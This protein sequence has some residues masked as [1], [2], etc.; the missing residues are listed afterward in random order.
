MAFNPAAAH[1]DESQQL[2]AAFG[3]FM[4]VRADGNVRAAE[5]V[6]DRAGG[7][8]AVI[9]KPVSLMGVHGNPRS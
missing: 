7:G 4:A 6:H 8:I 3:D 1:G 9:G 2:L 5:Q